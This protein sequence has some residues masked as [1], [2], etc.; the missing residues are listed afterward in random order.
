M[1]TG[2][3]RPTAERRQEIALAVLRIVGERGLAALTTTTLAHEIGVT[4]GALFRH[5]AS[6]DEILDATVRHAIA[7]IEATFPAASL[8]PL[9]RLLALARNRVQLLA[10]DRGLAWLLR[11]EQAYLSLPPA[12]VESLGELAAKSKRFLLGAVREGVRDGSIRGDI[13]PQAMVVLVMGT[14]HALVGLP[15]VQG[16]TTRA[17]LADVEQVLSAL[18]RVLVP[19]GVPRPGRRATRRKH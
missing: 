15:G 16:R 4:S 8:P 3:R 13:E 9:E 7:R 14:I 1:P 11:S 2:T 6:R 18:E 17:G 5:F 10:S 12:A 19:A